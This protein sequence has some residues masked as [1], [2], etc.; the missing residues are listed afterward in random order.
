MPTVDFDF[1]RY[2]ARKKGARAAQVR[3]GAAY[4]YPGDVRLLRTL[5]KLRP[6]SLV[7]EETGRLWKS[8]ARAEVLGTA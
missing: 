7:L 2:V 1:Q 6:V 3:E 5:D 8:V 4:A